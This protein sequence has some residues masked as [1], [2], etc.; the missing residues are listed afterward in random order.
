MTENQLLLEIK[1]QPEALRRLYAAYIDRENQNLHQAAE[2]VRSSGFTIMAGMATSEYANYAAS[3]LLNNNAIPNFVYDVS[4]LLYYH[5]PILF[6][7]GAC[8]V[9]VS[10]S[11]NSAEIV[12]I[13]KEVKGKVPIIGVFN[14]ETSYLAQNCD[15][16]LP[17]YAGPQLACG[18]KTNLSSVAMLNL[19]AIAA[20]GLDLKAAGENVLA[21]AS[22]IQRF[23]SDW[24]TQVDPLVEF[25]AGSRYTVFLGRGPGRASAMFSAT[26]FRE[27]PKVVAE[28]MGAAAFRHGLREMIQ[29]EDRVVIFAPQSH[30]QPYLF[31]IVEDLLDID[32]PVLLVCN[33][34]AALAS[35]KE[36]QVLRTEYLPEMWAPLLDMV[37]LQLAGY[38]LAKQ[39]GIEPGKLVVS[40]YVTTVE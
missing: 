34:D 31:R 16:P 27:V 17:I 9:L 23:L 2:L 39:R 35:G 15:I 40:T 3:S 19:L 26:L 28:G 1:E 30:T 36:P 33:S 7:P 6:Q 37:P 13:L 21:S 18:S 10:Q 20:A 5:L 22:S 11:G 12:H 25:L 8:L 14:D 4:E 38:E 29:P 24:Q 32:V